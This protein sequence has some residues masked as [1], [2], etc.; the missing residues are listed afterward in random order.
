MK[1]LKTFMGLGF[2]DHFIVI[3][4]HLGVFEFRGKAEPVDWPPEF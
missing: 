3:C 2:G 1:L 4:H